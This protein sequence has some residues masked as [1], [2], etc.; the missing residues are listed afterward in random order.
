MPKYNN[1]KPTL[2]GLALLQAAASLPGAVLFTDDFNDGVIDPAKWTRITATGSGT[3]W[4]TSPSGS[5]VMES[6]GSITVSQSATDNGG[7]I[8]SA[9]IT[10][11]DSGLIT[12]D[13][14]TRVHFN[15][16]RVTQ[17]EHLY[18][19]SGAFLMRWGYFNYPTT[20]VGF[21]SYSDPLITGVWDQWIS[22]TISYDPATGSAS[23]TINGTYDISGTLTPAGAGVTTITGNPL[24]DGDTGIYLR[25]GAYGWFTGHTKE[26]DSMTVSQIPEPSTIG[27]LALA[28]G[29]M[30]RRRR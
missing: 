21:G 11:E 8:Q 26:L 14:K 28:L 15:G 13:R 29:A 2:L 24:P 5:T 4:T 16:N 9:T 25:T 19:N 22:E 30:T 3:G 17:Y 18:S 7:A 1:M 23:Y 20:W 10:V 6:G 12:I 27:F